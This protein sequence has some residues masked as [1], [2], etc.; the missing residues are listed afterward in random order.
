M[1]TDS[2]NQDASTLTKKDVVVVWGAANDIE[3]MKQT[4]PSL[5]SQNLSN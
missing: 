3:K 5:T 4:M 1:I 2:A